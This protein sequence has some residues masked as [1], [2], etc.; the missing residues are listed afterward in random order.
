MGRVEGR[1][2][3]RDSNEGVNSMWGRI[4]GVD[5]WQ[6]RGEEMSGMAPGLGI[7]LHHKS[8]G[9]VHRA[10]KENS[11]AQSFV[12]THLDAH[13]WSPAFQ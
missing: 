12:G 5:F 2:P 4:L 11:M 3:D 7:A 9:R 8:G 13:V 6:L 10:S 1:A